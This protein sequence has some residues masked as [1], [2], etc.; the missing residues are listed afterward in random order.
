[1]SKI[2]KS[3]SGKSAVVYILV[4]VLCMAVLFSFGVGVFFRIQ[5][6]DVEGANIY[7][8][9][10]IISASELEIGNSMFSFNIQDTQLQIRQD[11]PFIYDVIVTRVLPNRIL[12]EVI[13]SAPFATIEYRNETLIIDSSGRVLEK[14]STPQSD[15]IEIRG[16]DVVE[17]QEGS[18][19]S[20]ESED[21]TRLTSL[22]DVM[23]AMQS[24]GIYERVTFLDVGSIARIFFDFDGIRID[25]GTPGDL[26]YRLNGLENALNTSRG[27]DEHGR[28]D[29]SGNP[30]WRWIPD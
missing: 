3:R 16:F 21:Q 17:P 25:L 13:E 28:F 19:L 20:S 5:Y 14:V 29:I 22:I 10:D 30:P 2:K 24:T 1:M 7:L 8:T 23:R 27:S 26:V 15:L 4:A 12:I 11:K 18:V 6:I 9:D